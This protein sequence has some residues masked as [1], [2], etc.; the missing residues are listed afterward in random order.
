MVSV[1]IPTRDSAADLER[2]FTALAPAAVEGLVREVLAAD[3]G[4][5][6]ST[7]VLCED[8]G[9][10][11]VEGSVVMAAFRARHDWLLFLD[12]SFR[13]RAGWEEA[14]QKHLGRGGGAAVLTP[15]GQGWLARLS[16]SGA[17][18]LIHKDQLERCGDGDDIAAIR[19]R[20]AAGA[21]RL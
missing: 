19:K 16:G 3:A 12:P 5:T 6:D 4:S 14:L 7:K 18:V 17:G 2:L 9:A 13:P 21:A 15:E 11:V 20:F 1:I 10:E 8:V